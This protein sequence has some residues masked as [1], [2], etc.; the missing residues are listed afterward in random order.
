MS[1]TIQPPADIRPFQSEIAGEKLDELRDRIAAIALSGFLNPSE[2]AVNNL[3]ETPAD[4]R[5]H[6]VAAAW[7]CEADG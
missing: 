5:C 2:S 7:G 4:R 1:T 6:Y 3:L